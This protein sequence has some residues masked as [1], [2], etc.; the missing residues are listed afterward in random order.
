MRIETGG[1]ALL[2]L[3]AE[4]IVLIDEV[5]SSKMIATKAHETSYCSHFN[6]FKFLFLFFSLSNRAREW[7]YLQLSLNNSGSFAV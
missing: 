3:E 4:D 2:G 1:S 6:L 5:D 7:E